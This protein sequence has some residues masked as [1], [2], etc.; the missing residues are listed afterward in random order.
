MAT[1]KGRSWKLE[2]ASVSE[3]GRSRPRSNKYSGSDSAPEPR[4]GTRNRI[5]VGGY[6]KSDGTKIAGYYRAAPD[7][8]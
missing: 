5:W 2:R 1:N 8:A 4:P 3:R 6:T 7:K